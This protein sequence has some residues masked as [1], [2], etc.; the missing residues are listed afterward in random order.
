MTVEFNLEGR[1][2]V[3]LNGGPVFKFTEAISFIVNCE[4]QDELDYYWQK[5]SEG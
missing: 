5:L 4:T 1:E 3:A 2:F